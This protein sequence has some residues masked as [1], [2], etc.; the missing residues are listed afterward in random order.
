MENK[1]I[2]FKDEAKK[3][4]LEGVNE[5]SNAV[6]CTLGPSGGCIAI[7]RKGV[8][9]HITKDGVTVAKSISFKDPVKNMGASLVKD[10]ASKSADEA[11]DGTTTATVLTKAIA[12]SG[13]KAIVAGANPMEL[14]K[15]MDK[16]VEFAVSHIKE[17]AIAVEDNFDKIK[18]IA[19]ISANNDESIG[20]VIADALSKVKK[21][22]ILTVEESKEAE[23]YLDFVEGMQFDKGFCSPYFNTN[24]EKQE[25]ILENPVIVF[26][27]TGISQFKTL[28]PALECAKGRPLLFIAENVDG[29]ALTGLVVNHQLKGLKVCAVKA[30]SFGDAK[31]DILQDLATITGGVVVS[32]DRGLEME[33]FEES[34]FGKAE[35]VIITKNTTTIVNGKGNSEEIKERVALLKNQIEN[36]TND[37]DKEKFKER[38]AKISGGVAVIYVGA[39][40]E[41]EMKEKKDRVDDALCATRAAIEEG[42]IP[43]GSVCYIRASQLL[44]SVECENTDQKMG[45]D[46]IKEALKTPIK[47]IA[48]NV[49]KGIDSGVVL[50][51]IIEQDHNPDWYEFGYNA[52][53]D[54]YEGLIAAGILDPA[55]VARVALQNAVSIASMILVTNCVIFNDESGEDDTINASPMSM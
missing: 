46:I 49:G 10:V 21:D 25:C 3:K 48:N 47:I 13:Y 4:L 42:V 29:E 22:G 45:L 43:G 39:G 11:G 19:T 32:R 55:K 53:E 52:K 2:I 36:A 7:Q 1:Q 16:A 41:T 37:Y 5:L 35:K 15:G 40:S 28:I 27:E 9:P 44:D 17:N 8:S 34:F 30:P 20:V 33:C 23:T 24:K 50:N 51:T 18:Q 12:N 14:K 26:C 54:K 6:E 31:K 38:L